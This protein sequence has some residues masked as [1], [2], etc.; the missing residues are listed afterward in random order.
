MT[1]ITLFLLEN[2]ESGKHHPTSNKAKIQSAIEFCEKIN[3]SI[4]CDHLNLFR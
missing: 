4:Y 3:M 2:Y 1:P